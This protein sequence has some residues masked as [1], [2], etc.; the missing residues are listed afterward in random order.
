MEPVYICIGHNFVLEYK[1]LRTL[2]ATLQRERISP[3]FIR[4]PVLQFCPPGVIYIVII[5]CLCLLI[6]REATGNF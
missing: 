6:G 5:I 2:G 4:G 3:L 1:L